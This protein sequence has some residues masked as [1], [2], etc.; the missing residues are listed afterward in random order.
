M[1]EKEFEEFSWSKMEIVVFKARGDFFSI[2]LK[3]LITRLMVATLNPRLKG[4]EYWFLA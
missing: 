4:C 2:S 1:F 3:S